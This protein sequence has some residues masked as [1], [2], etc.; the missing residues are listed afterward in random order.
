[1][2]ADQ[3]PMLARIR[4]L[5]GLDP[6]PEKAPRVSLRSLIEQINEAADRSDETRLHDLIDR[7]AI[8]LARSP[9]LAESVARARLAGG[10]AECALRIVE[11]VRQPGDSLRL[12]RI[13]CQLSTGR[14][15]DAHAELLTWCRGRT[16]PIAAFHLLSL[17]ERRPGQT[18]TSH[19]VL[20][21]AQQIQD[22]ARTAMLLAI[23]HAE[24]GRGQLA[25]QHAA[26]R[27]ERLRPLDQRAWQAL[28]L[29]AT[30]GLP[31]GSPCVVT[32]AQAL[33]LA[34]ELTI[35]AGKIDALVTL[36]CASGNVQLM[37]LLDRALEFAAAELPSPVP[38]LIG[39]AW[40]RRTEGRLDEARALATM[41]GAIEPHRIEIERLRQALAPTAEGRV[42]A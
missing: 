41:A 5:L 38:A 2:R 11:C 21:T 17:L 12:L 31:A 13:I 8:H 30:L 25:A 4:R 1:M 6:A 34:A 26:E 9:S 18:T 7:A 14:R 36:A 15:G 24:E 32:D 16:A 35:H 28:V 39:Q 23:H 40:L 42:A 29:R 20:L 19:S 33:A 22:D 37:N 10:D 27:Y 3:N